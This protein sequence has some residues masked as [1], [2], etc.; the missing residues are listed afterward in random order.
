MLDMGLG[1]LYLLVLVQLRALMQLSCLL[2]CLQ[3]GN[4]FWHAQCCTEW[5]NWTGPR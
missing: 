1:P 2:Q 5:D 4:N 3:S